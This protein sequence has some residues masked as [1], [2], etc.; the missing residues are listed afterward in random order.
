M[1]CI[2]ARLSITDE[3]KEKKHMLSTSQLLNDLVMF[4]ENKN[5]TTV[6]QKSDL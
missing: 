4:L 3:N 2:V 5:K 6:T 1:Q